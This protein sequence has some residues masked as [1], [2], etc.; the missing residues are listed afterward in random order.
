MPS[1]WFEDLRRFDARRPSLPGE[2]WLTFAA[3]VAL[4]A[5]AARGM[6]RGGGTAALLAG[7]GLVARAASG[8][9]GPI[10]RLRGRVP[11]RPAADDR[12]TAVDARI[13]SDRGRAVPAT[14]GTPEHPPYL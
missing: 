2:H 5:L 8:R 7:L 13:V 9:D 12:G 1:S 11:Y 4:L 6:R 14:D 3:G 10:A